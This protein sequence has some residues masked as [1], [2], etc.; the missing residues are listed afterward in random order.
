MAV[1]N[2]KKVNKES[3][4]LY[5]LKIVLYLVIGSQWIRFTDLDYTN[6]LPIPFGLMIGFLFTRHE[7]FQIDKKI[8]YAILLIACFVGFWTQTGL[9]ITAFS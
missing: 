4:G 9:V 2:K 6:Q 1:K 8:E 5:F 3:D 7:H